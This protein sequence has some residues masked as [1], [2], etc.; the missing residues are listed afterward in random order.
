MPGDPIIAV[1]SFGRH[2]T[3][4]CWVKSF[5]RE[6]IRKS[7]SPWNVDGETRRLIVGIGPLF[8]PCEGIEQKYGSYED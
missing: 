6:L 8:F 3:G 4:C 1:V 2:Q 5:P 7:E